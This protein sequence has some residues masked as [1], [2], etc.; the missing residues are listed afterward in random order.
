MAK[1]TNEEDF[2]CAVCGSTEY[3]TVDDIC[4]VCGWARDPVQE[5]NP[6]EEACGNNMSLNQARAAWAK[7][8]KVL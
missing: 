8:E 7:G 5:A 1:K 3:V 6:D 2:K 4:E